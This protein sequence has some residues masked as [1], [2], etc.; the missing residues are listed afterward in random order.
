[1]RI[2]FHHPLPI[3]ADASSA[4]GIRPF[5]MI[6][7]FRSLGYE[8][9]TVCGYAADRARAIEAVDARIRRGERYAFM[10]SESSTEPTLLTDP[11]HLPTRPFLDFGFFSRL[12]ARGVP[13]GLFYRDI[14]WRFPG[15]GTAL[16]PWKRSGARLMYRYDLFQYRR[17]LDRL[18]L[19]SMEMARHVPWFRPDCMAALPPGYIDRSPVRR[20]DG[21]LR[22]LYIGGFGSHY[23]MHALFRALHE[24]PEVHL[25]LCTREAEWR[26]V[27]RE[28][29]LPPAGNIKVVHLAGPALH[30][31]F[32]EAE[33]CLL[34]VEPQAYWE[35]AAPLKLYEYIGAERPVIASAGTLAGG[36]V[37]QHDIG[38]TLPYADEAIAALLRQLS[39]NRSLLAP[40]RDALLRIRPL[41]TW[42]A[43]AQQVALDLIGASR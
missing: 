25:T 30:A 16:A 37:A 18:Y 12:K 9:D 22:L 38:W 4:S 7:A 28:Y 33:A 8:V 6:E 23:R 2:V 10:Y 36:F 19:P 15:Y 17:L 14:Y 39:E 40:K 21:T 1:M 11:H 34:F 26:A 35:F 31:L 42:Q 3:R 24:L 41:H 27:R 5:Q 29:P 32:E 13:L 20:A 43:R